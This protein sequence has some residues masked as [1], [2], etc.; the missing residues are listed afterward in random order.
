[1]KILT[2]ALIIV[3]GLAGL[4][5]A[6]YISVTGL[7]NVG[8]QPRTPT[9]TASGGC[10]SVNGLPDP[11]CTPG[12]IDGNVT[13]DNIQST[14]CVPGYSSSV[15]PPVSYTEPLKLES[16]KQYGYNDTSPSDYEFDHLI[17]LELGGNP[18]ATS[19]LWAEPHYGTYTSYE[20]DGFENYLHGQVCGGQLNL[21]DAQAEIATDWVKYW[22]TAGQP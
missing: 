9:S 5:A 10:S 16:I 8:A 15:R 7:D 6:I 3:L 14:I 20:K 21:A 12:S 11:S 18:T 2:I 13:Q 17:P 22:V 1:M 19:N 4:A